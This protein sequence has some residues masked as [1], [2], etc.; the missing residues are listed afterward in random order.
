M[1]HFKDSEFDCKCGCGRN[2]IKGSFILLL[3]RAREIAGVPFIITSGCRCEK[4]NETVGSA[5][6]NHVDGKAAD[7]LCTDGWN[8][9]RI[10]RALLE[11]GFIRIGI[12]KSFIHVDNM[13]L[14]ASMWVY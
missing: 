2:N 3:N 9:L 13:D 5:S 4:H 10:I 8:R 7:I 12:H 6:K 14:P 1:S 11:V